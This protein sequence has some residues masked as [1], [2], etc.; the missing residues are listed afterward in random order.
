MNTTVSGGGVD[1]R[2]VW[3]VWGV[4]GGVAAQ[5]CL[6]VCD[7]QVVWD[8]SRKGMDSPVGCDRIDGR[9]AVS[10]PSRDLLSGGRSAVVGAGDVDRRRALGHRALVDRGGVGPD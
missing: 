9:L 6:S 10:I 5:R 1:D 7:G 2:C 3:G 8:V 4:C